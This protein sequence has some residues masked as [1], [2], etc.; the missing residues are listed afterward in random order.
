M[1]L[2]LQSIKSLKSQVWAGWLFYALVILI[3]ID[4]PFFWDTVNLGSRYGQWYLSTSFSELLPPA[5]INSGNPPFWGMYLGL[6]WSALGKHLAVAHLAMLPVL[7]ALTYYYLSVADYFLGRHYLWWALILLLIEPTMLSQASLCGPDVALVMFY[8]M[9]L[10][11]ILNDKWVLQAIAMCGLAMMSSRGI[12]VLPAVLMTDIAIRYFYKEREL[13]FF[14][15]YRYLPVAGVVLLWLLFHFLETGWVGFNQSSMP[16]AGSFIKVDVWGIFRNL[17]ILGWRLMDFGRVFIWFTGAICTW[18]FI[19]S[20]PRIQPNL[21]ALIA[22]LVMPLLVYGPI[23]MAFRDLLAHRYLL[24][25]FLL[26]GLLVLY[27]IRYL[28]NNKWVWSLGSLVFIGLLTGHLWVYP[29]AVAQGWDASLAHQ[30][31]FGVRADMLQYMNEED[32]SP[33]EVSTHFP[34]VAGV[35]DTDLYETGQ[36]FVN[37]NGQGFGTKKYTLHSNVNNDF[38]DEELAALSRDWK[39]VKEYKSAWVFMRLYLNPDAKD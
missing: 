30:P 27:G 7:C 6:W 26:F 20:Q 34:M 23:M 8:F 19:R 11:A 3:F 24:I 12:M 14:V 36:P 31:Y 39:M 2:V 18:F 28:P 33:T 17:L 21:R 25:L 9:T 15:L 22:C 1:S 13:G 37:A 10:H 32:I 38:S 29:V 4:K 5:K 16:W 35:H